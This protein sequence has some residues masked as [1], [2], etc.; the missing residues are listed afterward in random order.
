MKI[1]SVDIMVVDA[2]APENRAKCRPVYCR[3][4]TSEGLYGDGEAG[5]MMVSG[6]IGA[7]GVLRDYAEPIIGMD[8]IEN[9]VIMGRLRQN[10]F[11]VNGGPVVQAA[12]S[13]IDM[14]LWDIKGK[15]F[16]VPI[17]KLL[18]GKR[19]DNLRCYASQINYGWGRLQSDAATPEEYAARAAAAVAE[20]YDAVKADFLELDLDGRPLTIRERRGIL[21]ERHLRTM[22]AR[23]AAVREAMGDGD[24]IFECHGFT[25]GHTAVQI[26]QRIEKYRIAY[27]EE[28]ETTFYPTLSDLRQKIKIPLAAGER[29]FSRRMYLPFLLERAVQ[30]IQPDIG[31]CGG[32]TEAMQIA[33]LAGIFDIGV[34]FHCAG[35]PLCMAATIQLEAAIPNFLIHEHCCVQERDYIRRLGRYDDIPVRG[36]LA[37]PQ[38][39]GIGNELSEFALTHCEKETVC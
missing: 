25:D 3:I 33:D 19:N 5:V 10:Y 38:R 35:S 36:R 16:G 27:L 6:G 39:P 17:Y 34:Q 26:A 22:E 29:L 37:I 11:A 20:G 28:P 14:A 23:V 24:I 1:T 21:S 30:V 8:P 12:L 15:A 2:Q 4:H 13:A 9:E 18:G 7:A 31:N 32:I